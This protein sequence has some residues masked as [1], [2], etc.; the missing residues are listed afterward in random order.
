MAKISFSFESGLKQKSPNTIPLQQNSTIPLLQIQ[1]SDQTYIK[2]GYES[3]ADLYSVINYCTGNAANVKPILYDNS[4][5]DKREITKHELIE[6]FRQPSPGMTY[7][8]FIAQALGFYMSTGNTYIYAPLLESG[9]NTGKTVRLIVLPSQYVTPKRVNGI[10][11]YKISVGQWQQVFSE[12]EILH[13]RTPQLDYGNGVEEKGMSALK[14]ALYN[15]S[16]SNDG[17]KSQAARFQNPAGDGLIGFK[18]V[19]T[20]EQAQQVQARL[21]ARSGPNYAGKLSVVSSGF[22]YENFGLSPADLEILKTVGWNRTVF[23]NLFGVDPHLV[24]PTMGS[25]FNNQREAVAS[26]YNRTIVPFMEELFNGFNNWMT[27]KYGKNL[28]IEIDKS[29]I[30]E[31][32]TNKVENVKWLAMAWWLTGNEKRREIDYEP[33]EDPEMDLIQYP[34][35]LQPFGAAEEADRK[36]GKGND[37]RT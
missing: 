10:K 3:N 29:G 28:Q 6:L 9:V 25:T 8:L 22:D 4:G 17:I 31:L 16:S 26:A 24:D 20:V 18:D 11:S 36:L 32:Q 23:C 13:I 2:Q 21:D 34:S 33:I 14:T 37:Y 27:Y 1:Q 5:K 30:P 12:E 15:I 7:R 35:N 19:V